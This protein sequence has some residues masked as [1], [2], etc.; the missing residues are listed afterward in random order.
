MRIK[1]WRE[2]GREGGLG[3]GHE[4]STGSEARRKHNKKEA[5]WNKVKCEKKGKERGRKKRGVT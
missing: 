3:K 1:R 2:A 4:G 5:S